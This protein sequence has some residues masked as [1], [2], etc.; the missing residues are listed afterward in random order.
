M[1]SPVRNSSGGFDHLPVL[2]PRPDP[3]ANATCALSSS[4]STMSH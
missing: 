2:S 3:V 1:S 4:F